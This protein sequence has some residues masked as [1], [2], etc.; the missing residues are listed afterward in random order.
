MISTEAAGYE[1]WIRI[2][3]AAYSNVAQITELRCPNCGFRSLRLV[4]VLDEGDDRSAAAVARG[5]QATAVFWCDTCLRGLMPNTAF[6]P[7]GAET[8]PRGAE[9]IPNY[10]LVVDGP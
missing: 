5:R 3:E 4:F 2:Y 8:V 1:E 10:R 9:V 7:D 6:V